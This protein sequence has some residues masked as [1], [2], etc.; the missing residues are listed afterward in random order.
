M[1][2]QETKAQED[3]LGDALYR[4]KGYHCYYFDAQK[5]G[6]S[7]VA[8]YAKRKPDNVIDRLRLEGVRR[9]GSLSRG[10]VRQALGRLALP[11]VGLVRRGPAAGE[12]PL[13]RR[14]HA[15]P[16]RAAS[17]SGA[18]SSCA[19]TGTS[20][21]RRSTCATGART[22]RTPASCREERAWLDAAVRRRRLRRRLPRDQPAAR[23][24]HV[25]VEPR[26]GVGEERRLAHRLPGAQ[27]G[28]ARQRAAREHLQEAALLRSRA[29]RDGL[30]PTSDDATAGAP[31]RPRRVAAAPYTEAAP[32]AA[33]FLGIS[34]GAPYAL[35]SAT[36]TTRLAQDG[37]NKRA[38]TAFTLAFL[39]YNLKWLWAWIVDGVRL[40]IIGRLGQRV[41]WLLLV[42]R[43]G[44]R[45]HRESRARRSEGESHRH[46][47]RGHPGGRR[48]RDLRHRDRC[49]SHR[50]AR[51]APARRRLGHVAV[52]LAH[53]L[54]DGRQHWRW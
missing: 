34:S 38:V 44:R 18:T 43:A 25:V 20:R 21:T 39:V 29:A 8:I 23:P 24:V 14:V 48:R 46:G 49:L 2:V 51:A 1:C 50:V 27:P 28:S 13:P 4:P 42:G 41:S 52:R 11:A 26:P 17:A 32:L 10:A 22:R 35:I 5:K 31:I 15:A 40:P 37:I 7:G 36:L 3:Q 16:A 6:Y 9:R 33:L 19:A 47:G 30:R 12:V 45:E 53:R 54:R